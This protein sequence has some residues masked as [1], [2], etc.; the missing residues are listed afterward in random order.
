VFR[1]TFLGNHGWLIA[2]DRSTLLVDPLL[3]ARYGWT[4]AVELRA[5]PPRRFDLARFPAVDAVLLTHEHEGHFDIASLH[6][7]DRAIP[8]YL[9]SLSSLA[10]RDALCEM[11]FAVH[12]VAPGERF[13]AGDLELHTMP[14]DQV[15]SLA[16]EWDNLAFLARDRAGDGSL[17]TPVDMAPT[18]AMRRAAAQLVERPGLWAHTN[19]YSHWPFQHRGAPPDPRALGRLVKNVLEYHRRLSDEWAAPEA[20]LLYGGGFAFGG[21]RAWITR[22]IFPADSRDAARALQA[23]LPGERVLAPAPGETMTMRGGRLVDAAARAPFVEAL[24]TAEWPPRGQ[25]GDVPWLEGFAPA[26]GRADF[27]ERDLPAL[28]E[29]LEGFAGFLYASFPFRRLYSLRAAE[30]E[31]RAPT[32]ALHLRTDGAGGRVVLAY[33]PEACR[34]E[35]VACDDP[36]GEYLA[37]YECWATDLLAQLRGEIASASLALG[38]SRQLAAGAEPFDLDLYLMMYAHPLRHPARFLALYRRVI[39]AQPPGP[40]PIRAAGRA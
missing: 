30:H 17:F 7:L 35:R 19:N 1:A 8:I 6:L 27:A 31:G 25:A 34:F 20:L 28:E 40:P 13:E 24:P 26:C 33:R 12:P 2:S 5:W 32:I 39:A 37:V 9:S 11:G 14:S 36:A 18:R 3:H 16:E 10:M 23:M 21:D 4:D 38:R 22:E 15:R 29:E